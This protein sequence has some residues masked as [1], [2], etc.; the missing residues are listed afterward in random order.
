MWARAA[1]GTLP[2][3]FLAAALTGLICWLPPGPWQRMLVPGLLVFAPIW[4]AT[5]A[6]AFAFG[7]GKRAWAW[8][9]V[10]A[11]LGFC[12]LWALRGLGWV[13]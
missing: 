2:G 4:M 7:T 1:A 8:L 6:L 11:L 12:L 10:M 5:I 13:A 3:F 9:S